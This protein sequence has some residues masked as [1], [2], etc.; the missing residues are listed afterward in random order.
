[1]GSESG[2][3]REVGAGGFFFGCAEHGAGGAPAGDDGRNSGVYGGLDGVEFGGH[4]ADA[5][6][7]FFVADE[8]GDLL[9][10]IDSGDEFAFSVEQSF[11]A[12]EEDEQVGFGEQCDLG[13]E[14]IV[15]AKFQLFDG[16]GVVFVDDGDDF[17]GEQSVECGSD[18]GVGDAAVE[19]AVGEEDL[20][21]V[22]AVFLKVLGVGGHE[23]A[24]PD[25]GAGL[26]CGEVFGALFVA[27]CAEAR[28]D[29]A[30]GYDED[31]VPSF[32]E[33]GDFAGEAGKLPLV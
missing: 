30:G 23:A 32:Y 9:E 24:L 11:D 17:A 12:G 18:V 14:V 3:R 4:A 7:A 33:R 8:F 2:Q 25:C 28:C 20:C 16:D 10:V 31:F 29:C 1:M 26:A 22:E 27:E 15:V 6:A 21:D 19:V 13:A 5:E